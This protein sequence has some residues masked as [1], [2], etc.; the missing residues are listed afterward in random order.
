M[1]DVATRLHTLRISAH[2]ETSTT[3]EALLCG[4]MEKFG[5][6]VDVYKKYCFPY[7]RHHR[8]VTFYIFVLVI[9]KRKIWFAVSLKIDGFGTKQNTILA[10]LHKLYI[11]PM[12]FS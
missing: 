12:Q 2:S 10:T 4:G 7:L 9:S 8:F 5:P 1:Q 3:I 11:T 6:M